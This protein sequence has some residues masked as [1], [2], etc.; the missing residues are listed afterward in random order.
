MIAP[1]GSRIDQVEQS[2][3]DH[4]YVLNKRPTERLSLA[5]RAFE[6]TSGRVMEVHTTQPGVQLYTAAS[7]RLEL[8]SVAYGPYCGFC[9]E[10]QHYPDAPNRPEFPSTVLRPGETYRQTTIHRF[11]CE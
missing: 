2:N 4:C 1:I 11:T 8:G 6:P 9:L 5:A 3:Y 7:M 10:T